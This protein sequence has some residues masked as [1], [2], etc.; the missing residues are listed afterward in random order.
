MIQGR[1]SGV[2]GLWREETTTTINGACT[3][4]RM[5]SAT[6]YDGGLYCDGCKRRVIGPARCESSGLPIETCE[7]CP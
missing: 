4:C 7:D 5:R 2:D 6:P 3:G 1:N